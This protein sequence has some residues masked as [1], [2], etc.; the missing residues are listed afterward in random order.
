M[1]VDQR[2]CFSIKVYTFA[3]RFVAAVNLYIYIRTNDEQTSTEVVTNF[4]I[5]TYTTNV[6]IH[7]SRVSSGRCKCAPA[8]SSTAAKAKCIVKATCLR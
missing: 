8:Q 7:G 5:V 3:V 6:P 4:T 1:D 2:M